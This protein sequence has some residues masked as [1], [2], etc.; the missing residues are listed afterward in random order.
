MIGLGK[1]GRHIAVSI[2][3]AIFAFASSVGSAGAVEPL[4]T[5]TFKE[6]EKGSTFHF[7]DNAPKATL[8]DG[9]ATISPGDELISTNPLQI[10]GKIVG[11]IRVICT[12]TT[13]GNTKNPA[14]AGLL[15]GGIAK[16]PGGSLNMEGLG[17]TGGTTEGAVIG[18]T[19]IYSGAGGSFIEKAG[20]GGATNTV[21][22]VE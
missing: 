13:A 14:S 18:G 20:K 2:T 17:G 21:T 7:L 10:E 5:L 15:C 8:K 12:A 3:V 19:G 4:P 1:Q 16:L 9:V 6:L 22:F 11:K